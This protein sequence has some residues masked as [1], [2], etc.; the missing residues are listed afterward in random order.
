MAALLTLV[1]LAWVFVLRKCVDAQTHIIRQQ[2]QEAAK[3]RTTAGDANGAKSEFLANMSHEIRTPLNG[4]IGMMELAMCSSGTEQQE[5]HSLM[6]SFGQGLLVI[7]N[8][9]L[10]YSKIEASARVI[11]PLQTESQPETRQNCCGEIQSVRS[12]ATKRCL[13]TGLP[14]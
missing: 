14:G 7:L 2:L 3:L 8:D 4:V 11:Q 1:V 9:I 10:D 6:K 5:Y 13:T 12:H